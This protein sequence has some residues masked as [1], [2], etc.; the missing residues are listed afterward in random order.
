LIV[1]MGRKAKEFVR[2][3]FLITRH[4]REYLI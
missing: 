2:Q 1:E 4:V 3:I